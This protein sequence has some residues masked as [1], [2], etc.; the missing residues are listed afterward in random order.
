MAVA[1]STS[2]PLGGNE[3]ATSGESGPD[4]SS[5]T[6][7]ALAR[8]CST[9]LELVP[10]CILRQSIGSEE[11]D[12]RR[13]NRIPGVDSLMVIWSDQRWAARVFK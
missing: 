8:D 4:E 2:A 13:V 7:C 1:A 3:P 5:R 6:R 12:V 10:T 11:R 9:E